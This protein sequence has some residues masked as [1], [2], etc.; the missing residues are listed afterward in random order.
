M[1]AMW[2]ILFLS[3]QQSIKFFFTKT[4]RIQKYPKILFNA[5]HIVNLKG[6]CPLLPLI[7]SI[8][9]KELGSSLMIATEGVI[10]SYKQLSMVDSEQLIQC[11]MWL[12]KII[13]KKNFGKLNAIRQSFL[14][15]GI[16]AMTN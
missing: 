15:Y 4:T 12:S 16:V 9:L 6:T 7:L 13:S 11:C 3:K 2:I 10:S 8:V 14:L 5:H 1:V